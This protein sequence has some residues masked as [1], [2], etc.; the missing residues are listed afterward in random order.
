MGKD[1]ERGGGAASSGE[2]EEAPS[3]ASSLEGAPELFCSLRALPPSRVIWCCESL[4]VA[5]SDSGEEEV[6]VSVVVSAV[7]AAAEAATRSAAAADATIRLAGRLPR[8][9]SESKVR[10]AT[11]AGPESPRGA[12]VV[13]LGVPARRG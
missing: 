2:G 3:L 13:P 6:E 7:A 4:A 12:L 9:G 11:L 1:G 5:E 10:G 8:L